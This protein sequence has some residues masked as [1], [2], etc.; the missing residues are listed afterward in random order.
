MKTRVACVL[1][2][3]ARKDMTAFAEACFR[4]SPQ[5]SIRQD[6]AVL[7]E[8]GA[9][10]RLF[11]EESLRARL[12]VLAHRFFGE[13]GVRIAIA[14]SAAG[15]LAGARYPQYERTRDFKQLPLAALLDYANPFRWD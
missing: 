3:V 12:Q 1:L 10:R 5:I 13:T 2:R 6:E 7:L 4:F 15:A 14:D 9:S 8:I 11:S